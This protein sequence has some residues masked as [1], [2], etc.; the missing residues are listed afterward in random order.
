MTNVYLLLQKPDAFHSDLVLSHIQSL[1][2]T[3]YYTQ[4]GAI[5]EYQN[6]YITH[7]AG[8]LGKDLSSASADTEPTSVA[9][10]SNILRICCEFHVF[11]RL[12]HGYI[13]S[14][15]SVIYFLCTKSFSE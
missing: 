3:V 9:T 5:L 6:L 12:D 14:D 4:I 10:L 8:A 7:S 11:Q 13:T 2:P 15:S 1:K